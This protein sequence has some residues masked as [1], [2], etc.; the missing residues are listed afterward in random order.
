MI[1]TSLAF[2]TIETNNIILPSKMKHYGGDPTTVNLFFL[3]FFITVTTNIDISK[4]KTIKYF[5]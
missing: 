5:L 3:K 4:T 2:E 1:D